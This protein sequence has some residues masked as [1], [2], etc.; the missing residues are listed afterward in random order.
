MRTEEFS[1]EF[2]GYRFQIIPVKFHEFLERISAFA[3][4][5]GGHFSIIINADGSIPETRLL[6][7]ALHL[8]GAVLEAE[9]PA[10]A[11]WVYDNRRRARLANARQARAIENMMLQATASAHQ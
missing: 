5:D 4:A 2:G 10:P 9:T 6:A 1:F 11:V 3:Y 8:M 7:A